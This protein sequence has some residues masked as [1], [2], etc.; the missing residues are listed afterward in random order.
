MVLEPLPP[1]EQHVLVLDLEAA[2]KLV[3]DVA[4]HRRDDPLRLLKGPLEL[5]GTPGPHVEDGDF[6]N[7]GREAPVW[8]G[9]PQAR[10]NRCRLTAKVRYPQSKTRES[11]GGT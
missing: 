3:R 6:E 7:H 1:N 4:R 8:P 2:L 11:K 9:S 5:G 10:E